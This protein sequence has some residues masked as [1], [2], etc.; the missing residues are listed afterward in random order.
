MTKTALRTV[1]GTAGLISGL[2]FAAGAA[3]APSG[4][5][6]VSPEPPARANIGQAVT[7][8]P[9]NVV[10]D[11][12]SAT[13]T[14]AF[15]YGDSATPGT[16]TTHSYAAP[17]RYELFMILTN[18]EGG[19][20]TIVGPRAVVVN[21]PPVAAFG[22]APLEP[23]LGDD[24]HF[25]SQS[26]DADGVITSYDW[27]FGDG[28][29]SEQRNPAHPFS[30]L[31][32]Q[33]VTLTVRDAFGASDSVTHTLNVIGRPVTTP[34]NAP[35]I[36]NFAYGPRSPEVGDSVE[37]ASSA[38][39]PEGE[40]RSQT[41]DLDGDSQFDDARGDEVLYT[42]ATAG[43]KTVRLRVEDAAGNADAHER[44]VS[45]RAR[46]KAKAGFLSP[47]PV[48]SLNATILSNGARVR[49]LRVS[50]PK[51]SLA[52]VR[53]KGKGCPVKQRRKRVQ[54]GGTVRLKTYERFLRAGTKLEIFVTKRNTIGSYTSYKIRA[55][56]FPTRVRR[57]T[58]PGKLKARRCGSL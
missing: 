33:T 37:F 26:D 24:V 35:P 19:T 8:T 32:E 28:V 2:L 25:G 42:F 41:W 40:L 12:A 20:P 11:G 9:A 54:K 15:T 16:E 23:F 31:G 22:W 57:C 39:D 50:A 27:N 14:V 36:A 51:G 21:A 56:K 34:P 4:T 45:V 30:A 6:T 38:V 55:G 10:F 46:P 18:A 48:I 7:I 58:P 13:G 29:T 53:C 44:T 17:G 49:V 52:T 47:S 1:A 43:T 5:F 3:A